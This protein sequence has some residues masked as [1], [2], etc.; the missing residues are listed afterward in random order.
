MS[1]EFE[2]KIKELEARIAHFE[3]KEKHEANAA[4]KAMR[5]EKYR[6]AMLGHDNTRWDFSDAMYLLPTDPNKND[7]R[8]QQIGQNDWLWFDRWGLNPDF[9]KRYPNKVLN[10]GFEWFNVE[11]KKPYFWITDGVVTDWAN[12]EGTVALMLAPGQQAKQGTMDPVYP[13][14]PAGADPAWWKHFPTRVSFKRKGGAVRVWV[15]RYDTGEPIYIYDNSQEGNTNMFGQDV[16]FVREGYYLDYEPVEDWAVHWDQVEGQFVDMENCKQKYVTFGYASFWFMPEHD[17]G[18]VRICFKN[19]EAGEAAR[20][21]FWEEGAESE[22]WKLDTYRP[23]KTIQGY[24]DATNKRISNWVPTSDGRHM[25]AWTQDVDGVNKV[26]I[27]YTSSEDNYLL[28]HYPVEDIFVTGIVVGQI[29]DYQVS[30]FQRSDNKV[31]LFLADATGPNVP[32]VVNCYIDNVGDGKSWELH[33]NVYTNDSNETA[34][35]IGDTTTRITTAFVTNTGRIIIS[36]M[37]LARWIGQGDTS[38]HTA[39]IVYSDDGGKTWAISLEHRQLNWT[40]GFGQP[41]QLPDGTLYIEYQ[42]SAGGNLVFVSTSNGASW[43]D[44]EVQFRNNFSDVCKGDKWPGGVWSG[45]FF[46]DE[47]TDKVYR[48]VSGVFKGCGVYT[49]DN[50]THGNFLEK[51]MWKFIMYIHSN[52]LNPPRIWKTPQGRIAVSW[53]DQGLRT[54]ILGWTEPAGIVYLDAV[55]I[56]PDFTFKHPS[57]YT[58]GPRSLGLPDVAVPGMGIL[59]P[60]RETGGEILMPNKHAHTHHKGGTDELRPEDIGALAHVD[61]PEVKR[62]LFENKTEWVVEHN[63]GDSILVTIWK[64][65][66]GVYGYGVQPYGLSPYGGGVFHSNF[67]VATHEPTIGEIDKNSFKVTWL[68]AT[69]G[70]VVCFG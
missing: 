16:G 56:E 19:L 26:V 61:I 45:S 14:I 55:Q 8:M 5:D 9:I 46:Y 51:S 64:G 69:S 68:T 34:L 24:N 30:L 11:T 57:F 3:E 4:E 23:H 62:F 60:D 15:E 67:E 6:M 21:P 17:C 28:N 31:L 37:A 49:L 35:R 42:N 48:I 13:D 65:S 50:P 53:N 2:S 20:R 58:A 66:V 32:S 29:T 47:R 36:F 38:I 43:T 10:S 25:C 12:W 70:K 44:T 63:M 18:R 40:M 22:E 54:V 52:T 33:G 27:G 39:F 41:V 1:E 59:E 7:V